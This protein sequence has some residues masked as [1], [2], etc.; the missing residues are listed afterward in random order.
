MKV[1][2]KPVHR[3]ACR[4]CGTWLE[5]YYRHTLADPIER[6]FIRCARCGES[7]DVEGAVVVLASDP[8]GAEYIV[9]ICHECATKDSGVPFDVKRDLIL[10]E[11]CTAY[12]LKDEP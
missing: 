10:A 8:H 12:V 1:Q 7:P 5:H 4:L 2:N 11:E 6:A 3:P 9:P